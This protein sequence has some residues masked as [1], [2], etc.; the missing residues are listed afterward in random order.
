MNTIEGHITMTTIG[1]LMIEVT[2]LK[3]DLMFCFSE[4]DRLNARID[5][6][7]APPRTKKK[8][9]KLIDIDPQANNFSID[10]EV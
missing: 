10:I 5:S 4:I 6:L 7:E 8:T 2:K 3:D 9:S 1:E